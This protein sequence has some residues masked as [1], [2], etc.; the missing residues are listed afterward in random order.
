MK[1]CK[2]IGSTPLSISVYSVEKAPT[3]IH[4]KGILEIIFCL[5]GSVKFSYAY[6]EFTLHAGEYI[7]VDKDAYYLYDGKDNLCV[8]FYFDLKRYRDKY[9]FICNN[10][11]V[12]EGLAESMEP[13]PKEGHRRLKGMLIALLRFIVESGGQPDERR[14]SAAAEKIVELFVTH[15]DV[16]FFHTGEQS[17]NEENLRKLH[18]INDFIYSHIT[19]KLTLG[20]IAGELNFTEGYISEFLR[21]VS[22]GFRSMLGYIRAN[23]SEHYL[24][25]TDKNILQISEECGFSDVKYYYSAFKRW[26][27]CT[28]K[29]FREQYGKASEERISYMQLEDIRDILDKLILDYYM[30]I[31]LFSISDISE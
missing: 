19:E 14:V 3:H 11:F 29:Q 6:E 2:Q 18:E 17:G 7:S 5:K 22:I 10:L 31:F 16:F 28:P 25:K 26:Y 8:S 1:E 21:K 23:Q 15:F 30:D 27:R 20:D 24:L 12:C 9:P 4:D 13:Y